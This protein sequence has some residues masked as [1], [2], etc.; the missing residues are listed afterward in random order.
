MQIK[1]FTKAVADHIAAQ[2]PQRYTT[3]QSKRARQGRIYIDYLRNA[4]GATAI[5]AYSTRA[6]PGAPIATPLFWRE[7]EEGVRPEGF[8]VATVPDRLTALKSDPWAEIGTVRQTITRA[9][10]RKL[11]L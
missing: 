5:G 10:R 9:V 11:G 3:N 7:V 8:T 1:S 6:R 4:R 2:H